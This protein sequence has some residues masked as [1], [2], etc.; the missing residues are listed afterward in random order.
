[1][2]RAEFALDRPEQKGNISLTNHETPERTIRPV[3]STGF[4]QPVHRLGH[5]KDPIMLQFAIALLFTL[6]AIVSLGVV[7]QSLRRAWTA[8]GE[9]RLALAQCDRVERGTVRTVTVERRVVV[10][11]AAR[12]IPAARMVP[13]A[14]APCDYRVAA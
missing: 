14:A 13:R 5:S 1:M 7:G 9:L 12:F 11:A 4:P 6:A 3:F 10:Q 2:S 8:A